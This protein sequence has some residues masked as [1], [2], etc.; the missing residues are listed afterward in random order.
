V[1]LALLLQ[2]SA[3]DMPYASKDL[4]P[5]L[6]SSCTLNLGDSSKPDFI[7][8]CNSGRG[9]AAMFGAKFGIK[10]AAA[11]CADQDKMAAMNAAVAKVCK[12]EPNQV[13][14]AASCSQLL[15]YRICLMLLLLP[16]L[17]RNVL[18]C[19]TAAHTLTHSCLL[20]YRRCC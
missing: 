7:K 13:R 4:W 15:Q 12:I 17:L 16:L 8:F 3:P 19:T 9:D 11:L 10:S 6:A 14:A 18:A 20:L 1:F 5:K 2:A